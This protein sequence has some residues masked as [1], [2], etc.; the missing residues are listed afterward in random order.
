VNFWPS[1]ATNEKEPLYVAPIKWKLSVNRFPELKL[2]NCL[3]ITVFISYCLHN[4]LFIATV[5]F[6]LRYILGW[7]IDRMGRGRGRKLEI[8]KRHNFLG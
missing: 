6:R 8:T 7:W 2:R 3:V 1:G 4:A 5:L